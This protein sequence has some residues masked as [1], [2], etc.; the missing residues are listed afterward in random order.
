MIFYETIGLINY[1]TFLVELE[2]SE[3]YFSSVNLKNLDL[4]QNC[5][6]YGKA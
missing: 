5:N 4:Y 1:K 2:F 3:L 6:G